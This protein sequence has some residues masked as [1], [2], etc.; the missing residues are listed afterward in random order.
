MLSTTVPRL[1]LCV[2]AYNAAGHLPRLLESVRN[3]TVPFDD[4]LLYDDASTDNTSAIARDFGATVVRSD[5]NTGPSL[6]KNILAQ[7]TSAEWVHFHDADEAL[8][9]EFVARARALFDA[10]AD[11]ILFDTEDRDDV[12]GTVLGQR[13]WSDQALRDDAVGYNIQ[14][15]VTNCGVYRREPFLSTGGFDTD[16]ETKYNE[17][18]AMHLRLAMSG[19]RFCA[20]SHVGVIVYRRTGSM[21]S[22]HPIECARAHYHVLEKVAAATGTRYARELGNELWRTAGVSGAHLDWDYSRMCIGLALRL[23]WGDPVNESS[24]F[25]LLARVN[26]M[27][28]VRTREALVRLLKSG[29]RTGVPTVR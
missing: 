12:T 24:P 1:A 21:S 19:L 9:P 15:T 18:Q 23:G 27:L 4:V 26:P 2:P 13:H 7:R 14:H 3:Q 22:G 25:R 11:V 6:G 10:Q 17:D 28:A 8:Y 20:A 29:L 16:D 5:R